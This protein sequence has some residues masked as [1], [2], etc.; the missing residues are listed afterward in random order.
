MSEDDDDSQKTEEPT[1]KKLEDARKKGQLPASREI[2]SFFIM[3]AMAAIVL[4]IIPKLIPDFTQGMVPFLEA[5][6]DFPMGEG[7]FI[8]TTKNLLGNIAVL[9]IPIFIIAMVAALAGG[10]LQSKFNFSAEPLKPSLE[11]I[12]PMKGL[13]KM[14]SMRSVVELLKGILKITV[15]AIVGW[16]AIKPN[17][18][19]LRVLPMKDIPDAM[20]FMMTL[21]A[22]MITGILSVLFLVAIADY[23][24]QRFEYIKN[25]RMTKQ[26]IKEEYKQQEGDPHVKQKV[27]QLRME[28]ARKRMMAAVPNSDV[29]ITN[30]THYAV[31][32]RYDE[33]TMSAPTI[34]AKG[35][36]K[37]ALKIREIAEQNKIPVMR[38]PPLARALFDNG[39]I[40]K[41]IPLDH[42]Q[43]VAKIIGYVYKMRGKHVL[44]KPM[45]KKGGN[46]TTSGKSTKPRT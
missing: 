32:L 31:A 43:A 17:M 19:G 18:E 10:G 33:G 38:N 11:R 4:G 28:R 14:F 13:K 16:N 30:P 36:D 6:H 26:E 27:R 20:S 9:M 41:E 37:V 24:Y 21:V 25:L 22:R 7:A 45:E 46:N 42:Y 1:H 39:E 12:S 3:L 2:N 34:V 8:R 35:T 15:V 5:A 23:L 44:R 40:D 29:V